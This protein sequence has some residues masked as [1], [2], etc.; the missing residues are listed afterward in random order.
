MHPMN[1]AIDVYITY[2]WKKIEVNCIVYYI[3]F[4]SLKMKITIKTSIQ[5][6]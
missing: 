6:V 3:P 5:I 2:P 4:D 1:I